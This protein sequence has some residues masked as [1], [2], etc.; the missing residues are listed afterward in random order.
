MNAEAT[1]PHGTCV[2]SAEERLLMEF[3]VLHDIGLTHE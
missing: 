3:G 2:Y 1:K